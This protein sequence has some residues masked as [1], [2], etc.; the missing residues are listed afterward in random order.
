MATDQNKTLVSRFFD[1][2]CNERKLNIA[3]ELFAANHVYHDPQ[4]PTGPG[5]DGVRQVI[6]PYQTAFPDAH[7]EVVE[8]IIAGNDIVTRWKGSGT[9]KM[10]LL[11]IAPT[12]KSV[13]VDGIWI[14]RIANNQIVESWNAWDTLGMLQQ[15]GIVP[16]ME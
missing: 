10:E 1:E 15:L 13:N 12:G 6:S 3:D 16:S 4:S 9:Q 14:H 5:P 2:M 8:T 7:W 11:G